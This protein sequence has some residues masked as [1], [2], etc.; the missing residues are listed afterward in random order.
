MQALAEL[1]NIEGLVDKKIYPLGSVPDGMSL[2]EGGLGGILA[3]GDLG[4]I[5]ESSFTE[6]D[7]LEF[8][9]IEGDLD[10][11]PESSLDTIGIRELLEFS[12]DETDLRELSPAGW[13]SEDI[14][15]LSSREGDLEDILGFP[16]P[17][18]GLRAVVPEWSL[19]ASG[20]GDPL[21]FSLDE[22]DLR[23]FSTTGWGPG[24]ILELSPR[25]GGLEDILGFSRTGQGL[26]DIPECSITAGDLGESLELS[27]N[28]GDL[29][30]I[31]KVSL[32]GAGGL[33]DLVEICSTAA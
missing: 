26:G 16:R 31:L 20:L 21:E 18:R 22:E 29:D 24:G 13:G 7:I 10:D 11:T 5:L 23:E 14:L 9:A 17:S 27:L 25:D 2:V 33:G 4:D 1:A 28:E 19:P 32:G 8:S 6:G 12:L 3:A 15:E 30:G